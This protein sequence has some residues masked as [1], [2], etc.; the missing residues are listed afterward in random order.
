MWSQIKIIVPLKR[1]FHIWRASQG[2][3][4]KLNTF[5]KEPENP[6]LIAQLDKHSPHKLQK[7]IHEIKATLKSAYSR[8]KALHLVK[9]L[10][11]EKFKNLTRK[12]IGPESQS[13][14]SL[15]SKTKDKR[16][17]YSILGTNGEQLRDAILTTNDVSKFLRRGQ[18]EKA[19]F[20]VK[21]AKSKGTGGLNRIIEYHLAH[22]QPRSAIRVFDLAKKWSIRPN[23]YTY[24]TLFSGLQKQRTK[25]SKSYGEKILRIIEH[26]RDTKDFNQ[27]I[28]N[29]AL[30]ALANC[31]DTSLAFE[32]YEMEFKQIRKDSATY[33]SVIHAC[34]GIESSAILK[35][36]SADVLFSIPHPDIDARVLF[37]YCHLLISRKEVACIK[38]GIA[39]I[40]EYFA[41]G[42]DSP[43]PITNVVAVPLTTW[44]HTTM[45]YPLDTKV[46]SIL[47][48]GYLKLNMTKEAMKLCEFLTKRKP[49]LLDI[50]IMEKYI[51]LI[52][53][54]EPSTSYIS[55]V[56]I[57][58]ATIRSSR[59]LASSKRLIAC[60]Y[61]AFHRASKKKCNNSDVTEIEK[62]WKSLL[63][64][65][66]NVDG[67]YSKDWNCRLPSTRGWRNLFAIYRNIIEGRQF[68][69]SLR[70]E[71]LN[72]YL[73]SL[74]SSVFDLHEPKDTRLD[75]LRYMNLGGVR[76][77]SQ[78][79]D[80]HKHDVE[81]SHKV[82]DS[83]TSQPMSLGQMLREL[84]KQLLR[85]T[86]FV[87]SL[88]RRVENEKGSSI[89]SIEQ[90]KIT[91]PKLAKDA[92]Q[93][94]S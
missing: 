59:E 22:N 94:L 13:D 41:V 76:L 88:L 60:I 62:L 61:K 89:E 37:E 63:G 26:L 9:K 10:Y 34:R 12:D 7:K 57:Y 21:L 35:K 68:P 24:T 73:K 77:I 25:I 20:L 53:R 45:K 11:G 29:S 47:L 79:L 31:V 2:Y 15:L 87:E 86:E 58:Q 50:E 92:L 84:K 72:F 85:H 48:N 39:S 28:Y 46:T 64:F 16:L 49:E 44:N 6:K 66:L 78:A 67:V 30:S 43:I 27:T 36:V 52:I 19:V 82:K 33:T 93:L 1:D 80:Q 65:T 91:A 4:S 18:V 69:D 40:H 38:E 55:C 23:A 14:L 3:K 56:G 71:L 90:I 75:D 74:T 5:I 83:L 8:E 81:R 54:E 32:L 70:D 42:I 51:N 17:I